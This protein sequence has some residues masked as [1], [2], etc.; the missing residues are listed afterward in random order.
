MHIEIAGAGLIGR[1]L[2]WRLTQSGF[3][4]RLFDKS[5]REN[6][7]NASFVAASMLAPLSEFPDS[8][9]EIYRLAQESLGLWPAILD[10]LGVPFDISGSLVVSHTQDKPLLDKFERV[11]RRSQLPGVRRLSNSEFASI[12]PELVDRFETALFLPGEGWLDNR[13]LLRSLEGKCG[14][15]T[16]NTKVEARELSGDRVVDCRGVGSDDHELRGVRGEVIRVRAPEVSLNRPIRLMHPRYQ[17]YIAPRPNQTYVIGATQIES[18]STDRVSVRSALELLSAVYSL[19]SGFSEAE[20]L[21]ISTGT[22]AAY[23]DNLPRVEWKDGGTLSVNGLYRHGYLVAPA[24]VE[25][26]LKE[27]KDSCKLPLTATA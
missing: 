16:F 23:P 1:L 27:I 12:E 9:K 5:R 18:A 7:S 10:E 3:Q 25:Q 19:H 15:I 11:L 20:I 24:I 2:G 21:E 14:E 6:P 4:V 8:P 22:R 26:A 17:L 13:T